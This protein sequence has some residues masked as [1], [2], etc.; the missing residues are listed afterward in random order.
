MVADLPEYFFRTR[1]GGASVFRVDSN[2]RHRRIEMEQIATINMRTG[3]VR[4]NGDRELFAEDLQAINTWIADRK[5]TLDWR[6][7]D[8]ILR[9]VD[10]INGT[11][12][13]AQ[14]KA[15]DEQL[16]A[17]TDTLLMAMHD[18]RS[19]LVRKRA[20]ALADKEDAEK[21]G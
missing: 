13:W 15:S 14:S 17:V 11:A 3:E 9:T 16:E 5:E 6:E 2:N 8:D 10:Q 12:H 7:M 4:P 21:Q 19:V 18:L 20:N 1:E